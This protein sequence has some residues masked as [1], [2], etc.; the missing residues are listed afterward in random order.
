VSAP[1]DTVG[2]KV[3]RTAGDL[4]RSS[5]LH[6]GNFGDID[7]AED[8]NTAVA[9][10][11]GSPV[12]NPWNLGVGRGSLRQ[13]SKRERERRP[14]N[15]WGQV[16]YR[17]PWGNRPFRTHLKK[18]MGTKNSW[19]QVI[20]R[21]PWGNRPF[22]THLVRSSE[23]VARRLTLS[24]DLSAPGN[25]SFR[26]HST[27]GTHFRHASLHGPSRPA[28]MVGTLA[29]TLNNLYPPLLHPGRLLGPGGSPITSF[30]RSRKT[31]RPSH[32]ASRMGR[33]PLVRFGPN[34]SR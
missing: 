12:E 25:E 8:T 20:Y 9:E 32:S 26:S 21:E 4:E 31:Q 24:S 13:P 27:A 2:I 29:K 33:A 22:R 17:E 6:R 3:G 1:H 10:S 11:L 5:W 14:K 7:P 34:R 15:S 16:I 19:G 28:D 23:S 18:F 30:L